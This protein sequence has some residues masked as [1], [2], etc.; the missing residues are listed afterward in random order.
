MSD[1]KKTTR[2]VGAV[3]SV[4]ADRVRVQKTF[5]SVK[6]EIATYRLETSARPKTG[7]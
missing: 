6:G 4:P 1:Q 3:R 7:S 5:K 2:I